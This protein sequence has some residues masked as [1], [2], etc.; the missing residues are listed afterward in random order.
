[1]PSTFLLRQYRA[2]KCFG[3]LGQFRY[4]QAR[5]LQF[6]LQCQDN[7][8]LIPQRQDVPLAVHHP[9]VHDFLQQ[10][11]L[12]QC[13]VLVVQLGQVCE[14]P[15]SHP[16]LHVLNELGFVVGKTIVTGEDKDIRPLA[17][18]HLRLELVDTV[19]PL[20]LV[21]CQGDKFKG[22]I[23]IDVSRIV[24]GNGLN[25]ILHGS[26]FPNIGQTNGAFHAHGQ[27]Y[28]AVFH[29]GLLL[30]AGCRAQHQ[31]QSTQGGNPSPQDTFHLFSLLTI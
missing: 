16:F 20:L 17:C 24:L 25:G 27:Q 10:Q 23:R 13:F 9:R 8:V 30:L 7:G 28:L 26:A 29:L 5:P 3:I 18:H 19:A 4:F 31:K 12:L 2:Q 14:K 11:V 22:D 1:M 15:C 21:G 6:V